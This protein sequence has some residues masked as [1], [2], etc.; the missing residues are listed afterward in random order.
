MNFM[1]EVINKV[2]QFSVITKI[3]LLS[4]NGPKEYEE[5][6]LNFVNDAKIVYFTTS[7]VDESF[8]I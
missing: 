3:E 7:I 2:P 1:H 4:F 5:I 6:L 8:R